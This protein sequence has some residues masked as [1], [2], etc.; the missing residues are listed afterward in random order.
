MKKLIV[1]LLAAGAALSAAHAQTVQTTPRTYLGLALA[2]VDHSYSVNGLTV[3][4]HD[5]F[6]GNVKF[7]GGYEIDPMF[8]VE[9]G[10]TDYRNAGFNYFAPGVASGHG[11]SD[12]NAY[13]IAAKAQYPVNYQFTVYGK[14][15]AE[16][17]RRNLKEVGF[18]NQGDSADGLY[19][20]LGLQF[21]L[22]PQIGLLAEYE[23]YGKTKD[24]GAKADSWTIGARYSF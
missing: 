9:I 21:N 5:G 7:F 16:R 14:L 13:Y 11:T 8:A 6:N 17:S 15:G 22:T 19:A 2:S 10:Y 3:T 24:F 20:S 18:F 23:R 4:S 1:A 12:G